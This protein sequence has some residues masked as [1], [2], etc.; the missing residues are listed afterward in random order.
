MRATWDGSLDSGHRRRGDELQCGRGAFSARCPHPGPPRERG[1]GVARGGEEELR[2]KE[3]ELRA[4]EGEL[5]AEE[6]P[7]NAPERRATTAETSLPPFTGGLR[8]GVSPR[9]TPI[10]QIRPGDHAFAHD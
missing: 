8:G 4:E 9:L 2:A 3:D 7:G 1:G 5:R 10:E 6:D